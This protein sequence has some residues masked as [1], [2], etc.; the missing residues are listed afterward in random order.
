MGY[1]LTKIATK[2]QYYGC[3]DYFITLTVIV[4]CHD[5][6]SNG[7]NDNINACWH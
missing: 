6:G 7:D 3:A 2:C 1:R 5:D 4:Y